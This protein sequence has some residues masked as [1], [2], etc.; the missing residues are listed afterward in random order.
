MDFIFLS[1]L[2]NA[3]GSLFRFIAYIALGVIKERLSPFTLIA[4]N[5]F[6]NNG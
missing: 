3:N 2:T 1:S 6:P 4:F 5:S